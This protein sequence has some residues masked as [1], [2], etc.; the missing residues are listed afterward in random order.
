MIRIHHWFR[1]LILASLFVVPALVANTASAQDGGGEGFP[2]GAATAFCEP[3]YLGVFDGCTPWEGVTVTFTSTDETFSVTCVTSGT[4]R[5]AGCGV[6][7]PFGSTIVA[8]I[9]PFVIPVGYVLEGAA[10]QEFAIPDGPPEGQFGGPVFVLLP[11]DGDEDVE[12]PAGNF[13]LTSFT[14]YCEPGYLGV[15]DGCSP[16]DGVTIT[17]A[18]ADG[19]FTDSCVTVAGERAASC[20]IEVPFGATITAAIDPALIPTGY[21]LEG[22]ASQEFA[23]PD[24]PPEGLYSGPSFVLLPVEMT[25]E[26]SPVTGDDEEGTRV[27]TTTPADTD[28]ESVTVRALPSTG[29]GPS[30]PLAN[31]GLMLLSVSVLLL[32]GGFRLRGVWRH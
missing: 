27:N 10:S 12:E 28:A 17:F 23:I 29:A 8:S 25:E 16:W 5:A 21:V 31:P 20:V 4:E 30:S 32:V 22:D 6:D 9:D 19:A 15:F 14:A 24:G 26:E 1:C 2:L 3:G 18:S 13:S 7:V 11:A